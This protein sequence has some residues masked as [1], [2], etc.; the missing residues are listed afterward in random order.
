MEQH[1]KNCCTALFKTKSG[2]TLFLREIA[3]NPRTMGAAWP[4]SDHLTKSVAL[5]VPLSTGQVIE[6]GGGTG[7]V[8]AALLERGIP[9][10]QLLVVERAPALAQHLKKR[11]PNLTILEGDARNLEHLLSANHHPINTVVSSLPL[12]SLPARVVSE[13]GVQLEKV[14]SNN[15]LYIQFTYTFYRKPSPPSPHLRWIYSKYIWRNFPP[16]RID[17]F[18][19]VRE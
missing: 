14:L 11:F 13:I 9:S 10:K 6:L 19:Y 18:R 5:Q 16:A 3:T 4:S 7:V 17:V 8:T 1:K 15:A 2:L 12:R